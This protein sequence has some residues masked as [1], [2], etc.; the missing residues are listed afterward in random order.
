MLAPLINR[1]REIGSS[2][3]LG[4]TSCLLKAIDAFQKHFA[5]HYEWEEGSERLPGLLLETI[6]GFAPIEW[7]A[8]RIDA[9]IWVNESPKDFINLLSSL[10]EFLLVDRLKQANFINEKIAN[11]VVVVYSAGS[12]VLQVLRQRSRMAPPIYIA[13]GRPGNEGVKL[14]E[15]LYELDLPVRLMTDTSL[16]YRLDEDSILLL[17]CDRITRNSFYHKVGT[18]PLVHTA[19]QTGTNVLVLADALKRNPPENW[20]RTNVRYFRELNDLHPYLP[21]EGVLLEE[22]PWIEHITD[23]YVGCNFFQPNSNT[24][25]E[26]VGKQAMN[27]LGW[28]V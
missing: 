17:G 27:A 23:I 2:H 10:R 16:S 19:R 26:N 22:V 4:A 11:H 14:A 28:P 1:W 21:N 13:E 18:V 25:W 5:H 8:W 9:A 12:A 3:S 24:D 20:V 15:E 6:P 7:L